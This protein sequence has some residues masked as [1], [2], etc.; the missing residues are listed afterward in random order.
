MRRLILLLGTMIVLTTVGTSAVL[1]QRIH[2]VQVGETLFRIALNNGISLAALADANG[3]SAPYLIHAGNQITIPG[4]NAPAPG[5]AGSPQASTSLT[6][7][8]VQPGESLA[9]IAAKYGVTYLELASMDSLANPDVLFVGQ[10]L[11]VPAPGPAASQRP[12]SQSTSNPTCQ[13]APASADD[14]HLY[15]TRGRFARQDCGA[16]QH[17]LL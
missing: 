13:P 16:I 10:V 4:P 1:A 15:G 17:Q 14:R 9:S 3:L 5:P 7:H 11:R 8:T 6:T 2:I 12:T